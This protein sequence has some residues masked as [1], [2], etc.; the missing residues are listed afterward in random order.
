[1]DRNN[2]TF[3]IMCLPLSWQIVLKPCFCAMTCLSLGLKSFQRHQDPSWKPILGYKF[4]SVLVSHSRYFI[5][6]GKEIVLKNEHRPQDR[7]IQNPSQEL[8]FWKR[9]L[10]SR[11]IEG[12]NLGLLCGKYWEEIMKPRKLSR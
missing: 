10:F 2:T 11:G 7:A 4:H 12:C 5:F 8:F 3:I 6:L 9:F 1:M